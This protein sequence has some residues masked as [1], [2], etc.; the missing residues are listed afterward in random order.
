MK[1]HTYKLITA[2]D[3]EKKL[4]ILT[5]NISLHIYAIHSSFKV[6]PLVATIEK[7]INSKQIEANKTHKT[8]RNNM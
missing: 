6:L 1:M 4:N 3:K 7:K 2:S 8:Y 5:L